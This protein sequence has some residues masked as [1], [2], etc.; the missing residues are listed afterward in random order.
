MHDANGHATE[1]SPTQR[2]E[3]AYDPSV[4]FQPVN[5]DQHLAA[6]FGGIHHRR[7][8][9]FRKFEVVNHSDR[10]YEIEGVLIPEFIS[11]L[12]ADRYAW[13]GAE[14]LTRRYQRSLIDIDRDSA[15]G[16]VGHR[17]KTIAAHAAADIQEG[18][19]LPVLRRKMSSPAPELL[20]VL[21]PQLR[22]DVPFVAEALRRTRN[23]GADV[24]SL[25]VIHR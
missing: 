4:I 11:T 5:P 16:A 13:V 10:K 7:E 14:S 1:Q 21:W 25:N 19:P 2:V 9:P 8:R 12:L 3:Q 17:P 18:S 24:R 20:L 6:W 22:V 23:D 15:R